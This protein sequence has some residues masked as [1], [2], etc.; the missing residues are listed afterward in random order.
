MN[1]DQLANFPVTPCAVQCCTYR[2]TYA[3]VRDGV[4]PWT[5]LADVINIPAT[6]F[7]SWW[8]F[9]ADNEA[10][11]DLCDSYRLSPKLREIVNDARF[12]F[13]FQPQTVGQFMLYCRDCMRA[14]KSRSSRLSKTRYDLLFDMPMYIKFAEQLLAARKHQS[15]DAISGTLFN[16]M[17]HHA[18]VPKYRALV[19]YLVEWCA[20]DTRLEDEEASEMGEDSVSEIGENEKNE[21]SAPESDEE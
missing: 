9:T 21:E 12:L 18:V 5:T 17:K 4:E 19:S 3:L 15:T 20:A 7:Y 16:F 13:Y 1:A 10:L 11:S 6:F 2:Y 8:A 14:A